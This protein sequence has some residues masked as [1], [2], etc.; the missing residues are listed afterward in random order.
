MIASPTYALDASAVL[1]LLHRE[2]GWDAVATVLGA[3]SISSVN[4]AEVVQK[5]GGRGVD[6]EGLADEFRHLG[7]EIVPFAADEADVA[8]RL[9]LS[10]L[11]TLS[12]GDQACLATAQVR[13]QA[14]ITADRAWAQLPVPVQVHLI[15]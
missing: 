15:R 12:L 2:E 11:T 3:A 6:I 5:A 1:A 14:V 9:W 4:L 7:L 10:G 13:G 8:A